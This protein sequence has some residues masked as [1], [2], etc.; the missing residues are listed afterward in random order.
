VEEK[1]HKVL[2]GGK[3]GARIRGERKG[4]GPFR[5][6]KGEKFRATEVWPRGK[7]IGS[8]LRNFKERRRSD[9]S[10]SKGELSL[11]ERKGFT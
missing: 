9:S 10:T 4:G 6:F 5:E 3:K 1:K 11:S 7:K 2:P 8:F